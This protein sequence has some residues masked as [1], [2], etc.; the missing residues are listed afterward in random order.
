M[1]NITRLV[2]GVVSSVFLA[3]G[4]ARA[5]DKLDP[6]GKSLEPNNAENNISRTAASCGVSKCDF[7]G[8]EK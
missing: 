5:A 3:V 8:E 1:K 2:L 4:L 6:M 7:A